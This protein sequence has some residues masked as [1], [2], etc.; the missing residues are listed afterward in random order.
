VEIVPALCGAFLFARA[1]ILRSAALAENEIFDARYF[2]YKEDIE[3]SL[4]V[5]RAGWALGLWHG[6]IA[7]HGR[8]WSQR[9]RMPH[10]SRLRSARN[11]VRL[12]ASYTPMRLPYSLVKW[13]YTKWFER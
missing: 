3:L 6:G 10:S 9:K 8:G 4:R 7:W 2:A 1:K 13:V 12:H 5:R 11:E